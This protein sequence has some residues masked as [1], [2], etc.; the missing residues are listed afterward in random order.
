MFELNRQPDPLY[1]WLAIIAENNPVAET[2]IKEYTPLLQERLRQEVRDLEAGRLKLKSDSPG[3]AAVARQCE[4]L[5]AAGP[6]VTVD[7]FVHLV[8]INFFDTS[9]PDARVVEVLRDLG[10]LAW[11]ESLPNGLDTVLAAGG[12]GLSAGE[13]QILAFTR[14]FLRDPGLVVLDEASSRL[15]PA[16]EHMIERAVDRL[17]RDRTGIIIAHRL[18][19]VQRADDILILEDGRIRE[20]GSRAALAADPGSRFAELLRVGMEEVLV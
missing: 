15:D 14:V 16:T 10:L 17:L 19:T 20:Y 6:G 12:G 2:I 13:A 1:E 9:I 7:H 3:L 18:A 5:L 11:L 4:A 8:W